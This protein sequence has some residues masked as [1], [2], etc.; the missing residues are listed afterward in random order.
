[1]DPI[2]KIKGTHDVYGEE[3]LLWE[4][5][6]RAARAVFGRF[7]FEPL[8]TPL[9][10]DAGLFRRSVG[11]ETDIVQKE[12]YEF[13]RSD[14]TIALR[15]E[16]TAPVVR[17]VIEN[18]LLADQPVRKF[19]YAG[20]MFRAERPQAGRYRQFHQ[21]GVESFG[22][23][24]AFADAEAIEALV[25]F[26]E[27]LGAHGYRIHVNNMGDAA[28]QKAFRKT[29]ADYLKGKAGSLCKECRARAEKN[30]LR[31]LDCKNASCQPALDGAPRIAD[32][33]SAKSRDFYG[34]VLEL[35]AKLKIPF[36]EDPRIVRGLD[37]YTNT[38][39]EVKHASLGAQDALAAGGR[40]DNLV[41]ELGGE[42]TPA[43][44][45]ALGVERLVMLLKQQK[46][47]ADAVERPDRAAV[48]WM[49]ERA[50]PEAFALLS[51]LRQK[52]A[53]AFMDFDGRSL[54]S[55]MRQAGK[56]GA[57]YVLILGDAEMDAGTVVVKDMAT[58]SQE[59]H[60]REGAPALLAERLRAKEPHA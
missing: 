54:K 42:D 26:L 46:S 25:R 29:L 11:E 57:R 15:P 18:H 58:G 6:A 12:M 30:V 27:A 45:W 4:H 13:R 39:F 35:L 47:A 43:A 31:V 14:Q 16:G 2:Q 44:G 19:H 24:S 34:E 38:V 33:V 51:R 36:Q 50:K 56:S 40:Y 20:P 17:A 37:Y 8:A 3:A 5:A 1:M 53:A 23:R 28:D 59:T 9:I 60:P 49:G 48:V 21:I 22:S 10:E 32:A 41:R 55:Q 7:G 52:G